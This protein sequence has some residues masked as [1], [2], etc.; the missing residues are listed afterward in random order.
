MFEA[1]EAEGVRY[2]VIGGTAAAMRGANH[3][4]FDLDITPAR[5]IPNLDRVA[6]ALRRLGARV[7]DLPPNVAASFQLDGRTLAN[8]STWKFITNHGELDL[9]LD[10]DGTTGYRDLVRRASPLQIGEL[11]VEVAALEDVIRSKEAANRPRD[12]A[13]LDDLRR[14]LELQREREREG[15]QRS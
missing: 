2:V 9:A 10:P 15:D 7:F 11:T 3:V 13:V 6:A 4:T 1:L 14:T 8:G 5:D 12:R